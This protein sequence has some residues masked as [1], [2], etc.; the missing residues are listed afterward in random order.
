[1]SGAGDGGGAAPDGGGAARFSLTVPSVSERSEIAVGAGLLAR[2]PDLLGEYVPAHGYAVIADETVAGLYG[3]RVLRGVEGA[4]RG[5][6]GGGAGG[7]GPTGRLYTVP[8]GEALKTTGTWARLLESI[9][10]DGFGRD[11]CIVGLGGGVTCDVAGFVAATFL[12]GVPL[13]QVPTTL[14]AMVDAAIGGKTGVDLAAGKN[15]A[16]AFW[17]PRLV[18][19]DPDVLGT[20]P[21]S[22]LRAGLAEVVKHG[23]I[24]DEEGFGWLEAHASD[25]LGRD[26]AAL[27]RVVVDSVRVKM[28]FVSADVREG[29]ARAALNFGHTIAHAVERASGY[30][31]PHGPAVAMGMVVEARLGERA[32][33]TEGGTAARLG[34]LLRALGLPASLPGELDP[35]AVLEATRTDKKARRGAV[36]YTLVERIG[37]VARSAEGWTHEAPDRAVLAALEEARGAAGAL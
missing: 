34:A 26:S 13:V 9:A 11:A 17:Q 5:G 27:R 33:V 31:V 28:A 35:A 4:G 10:G 23:A 1:M 12:R 18:L 6:G 14:L 16:G 2:L 37:A 30:R 3:D 15:L 7:A 36:R 21:D 29:G 19:S 32:G 24:S 20:L 25:V 22:E 8:P